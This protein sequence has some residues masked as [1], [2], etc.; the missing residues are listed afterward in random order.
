M[1]FG[2]LASRGILPFLAKSDLFIKP[3]NPC[4][5]FYT[6]FVLCN[7]KPVGCLGRGVNLGLKY[8]NLNHI[9]NIVPHVDPTEDRNPLTS[10][11]D[12]DG[13]FCSCTPIFLPPSCTLP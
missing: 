5:F 10:C 2:C 12:P 11:Y 4:Q 13:S 7:A 9:T 6:V 1:S 8:T 3:F